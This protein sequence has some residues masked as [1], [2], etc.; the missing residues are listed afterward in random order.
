[1][2][3]PWRFSLTKK[4]GTQSIGSLAWPHPHPPHRPHTSFATRFASSSLT[5]KVKEK[6]TS[7]YHEKCTGLVSNLEYLAILLVTFLGWWVHVTRTQRLWTWPS[8]RLGIKFGH[9]LNHLVS[10][11]NSKTI[12]LHGHGIYYPKWPFYY[13][14]VFKKAM[15]WNEFWKDSI[16]SQIIIENCKNSQHWK[17]EMLISLFFLL[18]KKSHATKKLAFFDATSPPELNYIN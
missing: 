7:D 3:F 8:Q 16:L 9:E 11:L 2:G 10:N 5:S 6:A 13:H 14:L 4:H 18:Q 17:V 15:P 1:M 12:F